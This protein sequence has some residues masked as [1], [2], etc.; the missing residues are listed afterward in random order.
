MDEIVV[1]TKPSDWVTSIEKSGLDEQKRTTLVATFTPFFSEIDKHRD[2]AYKIVVTDATQLKEMKEARELRLKL[3]KVRT[4]I[5]SKRKELKEQS[6][7]ES[8]MVD[9]VAKVGKLALEETESYLEKQEKYAE[10]QEKIRIDALVTERSKKL[11]DIGLDPTLYRLGDMKPEVFE[12]LY[13]GEIQRQQAERERLAKEEADRVAAEAKRI[14]DER[15][16]KEENERLKKERE[17]QQRIQEEERRAAEV[18]LKEQQEK[19]AK[20]KK[21]LEAKAEKARKEQE[22]K[23]KKEREERERIEAEA[24]KKQAE[25]AAE[26]KRLEDEKQAKEK[27]EKESKEKAE[28]DEKLRLKTIADAEK[29]AKLAP[30][31]D[32]L[33][34]FANT[35]ETLALPELTSLESIAILEDVKQLLN[36]VSKFIKDKSKEL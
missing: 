2:D 22:A 21:E 33:L 32:K 4:G 27:A 15:K 28:R 18:K 3:V 16:L 6:L 8:N 20:E 5:E 19:A 11:T 17:E 24:K 12:N 31:K 1:Q 29:K 30:D 23:L 26:L 10:I 7:R 36:K 34:G 14:E 9:A 25:Q 13:N 35:I